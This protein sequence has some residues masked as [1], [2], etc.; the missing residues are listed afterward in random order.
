[1]EN[2]S[3]VLRSLLMSPQEGVGPP[4]PLPIRPA[5]LADPCH[6]APFTVEGVQGRTHTYDACSDCWAFSTYLIILSL[7]CGRLVNCVDLKICE[8]KKGLH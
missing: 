2:D 3:A 1:M 6:A 5:M 7:Q 4:M 8:Y